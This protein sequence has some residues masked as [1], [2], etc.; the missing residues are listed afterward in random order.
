M[1]PVKIIPNEPLYT[2]NSEKRTVYLES[3]P[4]YLTDKHMNWYLNIFS[5]LDFAISTNRP[6]TFDFVC[7]GDILY[8]LKY[9]SEWTG[10]LEPL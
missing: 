8:K 6:S 9:K 7:V 1:K 3:I 4:M 2:V 10:V 5:N